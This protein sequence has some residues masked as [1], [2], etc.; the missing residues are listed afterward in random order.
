MKRRITLVFAGLLLCSGATRGYD[1]ITDGKITAN[2]TWP[3]SVL[4]TGDVTVPAA[5]TLT[6]QPG[7]TVEFNPKT[8][9]QAGGSNGSRCELLVYGVLNASGT[10]SSPILLTARNAGPAKAPGDWYGIEAVGGTV[11]LKFV[12]V[13]Y[14]VNGLYAREYDTDGVTPVPPSSCTLEDSTFSQ[15]S[16]RGVLFDPA[17]LGA[18][19]QTALRCKCVHSSGNGFEFNAGT[20]AAPRTLACNNCSFTNNSS[21]G[22]SC[23]DY[24]TAALTTCEISDNGSYGI[25]ATTYVVAADCKIARNRDPGVSVGN[26]GTILQNCTLSG[27]SSDG[28]YLPDKSTATNC[29]VLNNSGRGI[30]FSSAVSS[31]LANSYVVRNAFDGVYLGGGSGTTNV[32]GCSILNNNPSGVALDYGT[33]FGSFSGNLI[34]A[35]GVGISI[36]NGSATSPETIA[37]GND[38]RDNNSYEISNQGRG[39]VVAT[40]NYFGAQTYTELA[41]GVYN[42][43]KIYDSLDDSSVGEVAIATPYV[44]A[45]LLTA[46]TASL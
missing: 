14:A 29:A 20:S 24:S 42:L 5:L 41:Q 12:T 3:G 46:V 4:V 10:Q 6:I 21:C 22:L 32:Q 44:S 17:S 26:S 40:G 25:Y 27:N 31:G 11:A 9:T 7:T 8:D 1:L 36:D 37:A 39:A 35:N 18:A 13:E 19:G 45:S 2:T 30:W 23:G 28:A 43:T 33:S 34:T 38:I 15:C 16:G